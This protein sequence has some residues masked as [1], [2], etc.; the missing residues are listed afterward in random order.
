MLEFTYIDLFY[1]INSFPW[2]KLSKLHEKNVQLKS[3][4]YFCCTFKDICF[5]IY[6]EFFSLNLSFEV[7]TIY[8]IKMHVILCV[9]LSCNI[10]RFCIDKSIQFKQRTIQYLNVNWL[11]LK[12][13]SHISFCKTYLSVRKKAKVKIKYDIRKFHVKLWYNIFL[14]IQSFCPENKSCKIS[15][16]NSF[17]N[18]N[19]LSI[20]L[21]NP[22][23]EIS[24]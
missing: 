20:N 10:R 2:N 1:A 22:T 17:S 11:L 16:F 5:N 19:F 12:T 9:G 7:D 14:F 23:F 3:N 18:L 15:M 6:I 4:N 8:L 13:F 21:W 24:I